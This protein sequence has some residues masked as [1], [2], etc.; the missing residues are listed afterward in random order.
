M[1]LT[2]SQFRILFESLDG[3]HLPQLPLASRSS[4]ARGEDWDW[5]AI[6]V[7]EARRSLLE[8]L[9]QKCVEIYDAAGARLSAADATRAIHDDSSWRYPISDE[10]LYTVG[11]TDEGLRAYDIN[12]TRFLPSAT[13]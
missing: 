4:G 13:S 12:L 9:S 1:E 10:N 11:V 5:P 8:L 7:D 3:S 2:F 6:P